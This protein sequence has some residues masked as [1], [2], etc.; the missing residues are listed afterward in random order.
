MSQA[1][2]LAPQPALAL[3]VAQKLHLNWSPQQ[4]A[5][6][7]ARERGNNDTGHVSHE[8]IYRALFIQTRGVLKKEI[9]AHLRRGALCAMAVTIA[10]CPARA[11]AKS[12]MQSR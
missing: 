7:F 8:T 3:L 2:R 5:A 12:S 11:A 6:W 10:A 4:I 9:L 1:C